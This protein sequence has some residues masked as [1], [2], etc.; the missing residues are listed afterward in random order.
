MEQ[1]NPFIL[2]LGT[3]NQV[4]LKVWQLFWKNTGDQGI[5]IEGPVQ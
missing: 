1:P 3:R 4:Y 5:K 2:L